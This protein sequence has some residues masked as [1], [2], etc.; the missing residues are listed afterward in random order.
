MRYLGRIFAVF[1]WAGGIGLVA[2]VA[3]FLPPKHPYWL[4]LLVLWVAVYNGP[5]TLALNRADNASIPGILRIAAIIDMVSYFAL[6]AIFIGNPPGVLIAIY[7]AVLI[8]SISF[9]GAI[10]AIYGAFIF[11]V[12]FAGLELVQQRFSGIDVVLWGCVMVIIATSM[13]LVSQVL[14]GAAALQVPKPSG[15]VPEVSRI[16]VLPSVPRLSAR[17][18]EVLKLVA[19]GYSNAMIA[20][21]LHLSENTVKGHVEALLS[22]LNARN[23]AEAVAAA[24][25]FDLL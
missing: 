22:R 5:L 9:D 7:P 1:R 16:G 3:V 6:L 4:A 13:T 12:G 18:H 23:R 8:E 19:D 2:L 10:G 14:L 11:I 25:R 15:S 21:R 20:T 17:E 24:G